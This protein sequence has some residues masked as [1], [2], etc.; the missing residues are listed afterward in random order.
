[1][2]TSINLFAVLLAV[3]VLASGCVTLSYPV[4]ATAPKIDWREY[5]DC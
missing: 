3:L 1:M 4:N 2:K 5:N